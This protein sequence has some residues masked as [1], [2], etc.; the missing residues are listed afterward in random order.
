MA[1][2]TVDLCEIKEANLCDEKLSEIIYKL[3]TI[4]MINENKSV[5]EE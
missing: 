2:I 1:R 5:K 3:I 4:K